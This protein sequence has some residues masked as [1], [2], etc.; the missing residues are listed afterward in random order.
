MEPEHQSTSKQSGPSIPAHTYQP[1]ASPTV[2]SPWAIPVAIIV[3]LAMI[4]GAIVYTGGFGGSE[5][6]SD[7]TIPTAGNQPTETAE[8]NIRPVTEDDHIRGNPNAPIVIVE[9]SDYDCPF[10]K[11]FHEE[12]MIPIIEKYG[13][14]GQVAWVH[15]HFPIEQLHPNAPMIAMAAECVAE[16]GGD[17]AFWTFSDLIFGERDTN[18]PTNVT[19]LPDY[20]EQA[21]V[22]VAAYEECVASG[23]LQGEVEADFADAQAA[24]ARGTPYSLVLVAGQQ[25]EINGAQ[26][27]SMV[28]TLIQNL[29]S[30]IEGGTGASE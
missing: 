22:D 28:D 7:V 23:R 5:L 17:E 13:P 3:G 15:R 21:G 8:A 10:C 6:T 26:P 16:L 29:L 14:S 19:A 27:F 24:G 9:Y 30:Q 12:T 25:G 1:V 20:A 11:R 2:G 4:A 18:E